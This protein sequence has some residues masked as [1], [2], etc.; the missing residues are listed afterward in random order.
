MYLPD[1]VGL[2][3]KALT[4]AAKRSGGG[5]SVAA[6]WNSPFIRAMLVILLGEDKDLDEH[7]PVVHCLSSRHSSWRRTLL[8]PA[9]SPH[10]KTALQNREVLSFLLDILY[11]KLDQALPGVDHKDEARLV[12]PLLS[13]KFIREAVPSSLS[14]HYFLLS[15]IYRY[16]A[17]DRAQLTHILRWITQL[18]TPAHV[19]QLYLENLESMMEEDVRSLSWTQC[20]SL[21]TII[22]TVARI[23]IGSADFEG[24]ELLSD[25]CATCIVKFIKSR[26]RLAIAAFPFDLIL[27]FLGLVRNVH[28]RK[29][30]TFQHL[31]T[32]YRFVHDT[33]HS[34]YSE[35]LSEFQALLHLGKYRAIILYF[36]FFNAVF[37][38]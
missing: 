30:V 8:C 3:L 33:P 32:I 23:C 5:F 12:G 9:S 38:S 35:V 10:Y 22:D 20:G 15:L 14:T 28:N 1:D 36:I 21:F 7:P 19:I 13:P 18:T 24:W 31:T 26:D 4:S 17:D 37:T 6:L 25:L 11:A 16:T 29:A 27:T 34:R 2:V